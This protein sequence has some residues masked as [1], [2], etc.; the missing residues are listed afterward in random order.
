MRGLYIISEGIT[1]EEFVN[2]SIYEYLSRNGISDVRAIKLQT[3]RGHKGGAMSYARYKMNIL[4][5]LKRENDIMATSLID[6]FRLENDFPKYAEG[7]RIANVVERVGFLESAIA[8]DM[9]SSRFIPYIQ[10]HEFE[11]L[12]FSAKKGFELFTNIPSENRTELINTVNNY[13]NPELINDG[14]TTAPSK[15]L[16][17]LIPGY[18]KTFHG[19][20][21][22][23][24]NRNDSILATCPRFNNLIET[25]LVKMKT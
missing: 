15:R 25:L 14:P 1:E 18:K 12:L 17:R 10:L 20:I 24:E 5:L 2:K 9:D 22:A 19:P 7:Q 16:E 6:F 13:P 3:S 11:G 21:I 8:E 23:L 4:N